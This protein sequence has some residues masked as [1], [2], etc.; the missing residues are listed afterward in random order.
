MDASLD[1]EPQEKLQEWE[2]FAEATGAPATALLVG[3]A[4]RLQR[5]A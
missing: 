1:P 4:C 5:A 2:H 3:K